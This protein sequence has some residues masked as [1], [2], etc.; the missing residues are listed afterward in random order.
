MPTRETI[1]WVGSPLTGVRR[2]TGHFAVI[3]A[4]ARSALCRSTMCRAMCSARVSTWSASA[5][6][7]V[8]IASSKS[9]GKRDMW[10]P[11]WAR[12]RSTVHSISAA[13]TVSRPS[14]RTR[15]A[16]DTPVTPARESESRTAG[17]EACRSW[18]S[19]SVDSAI[20]LR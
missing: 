2:R 11:F 16:F 18:P 6:T 15:T 10:T 8:S 9:S 1:S 5:P 17:A 19:T 14:C 3:R 13:M 4:S 12:S 7:T 20:R